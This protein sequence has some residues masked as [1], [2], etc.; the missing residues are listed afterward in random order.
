LW[1]EV[2]YGLSLDNRVRGAARTG[3]AVFAGLIVGLRRRS[4]RKPAGIRTYLI[5]ALAA[6]PGPVSVI[7]D[8]SNSYSRV[9]RGVITGVSFLGA[10]VIFR[11]KSGTAHGLTTAAGV[12]LTALAGMAAGAGQLI[13]TLL[14]ACGAWLILSYAPGREH[15]DDDTGDDRPAPEQHPTP[16]RHGR[17]VH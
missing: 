17:E 9:M 4:A 2:F 5:V 16:R 8:D 15:H 13:A 7:N 1:A 12:W 11:G 10:G 14:A 6:S 3:L